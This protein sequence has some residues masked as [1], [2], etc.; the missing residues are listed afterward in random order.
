MAQITIAPG[1]CWQYSHYVGRQGGAGT[2]FGQPIGVAVGKGDVMYV[3]N[4][5]GKG[6]I[7][8]CTVGEEFIREFGRAEDNGE[9]KFEW[10]T[11]IAVD[12]DE[13]VYA[14]DEWLH[15]ITVFNTDGEVIS[16]WGEQGDGE[17]QLNGPSGLAVDADDNVWVVNSLNSRIQKFTKDGEFLGGFG[18]KGSGEGELEL[19]W[20]ITI[21]QGGDIY[22]ADWRNHR[23]QKFNANGDLL[24]TF[25][26]GKKTGV[27]PDGGTPYSHTFQSRTEVNPKDLN[28]PTGIAVDGDGDVYVVDWMNERVVIFDSVGEPVATLRGDASGLS[29][30]AQLSIN[31]NPDM[32]KARR[33]VKNPEIQNYFRMPVACAFDRENDRL[34]V[35][36]TLRSRVQ[37]Y[38][39][40]REYMDPQFNL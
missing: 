16:T 15:R 37:V 19:P 8:K 30:W 12:Q 20:G 28:H 26:S 24:M 5:G 27:S 22:I 32:E 33:R 35:A 11:A 9:D 6:R 10:L 21:D 3:A 4:R 14:S 39:K 7:S 23:V 1:R 36:D 29:K 31:A 18:T 25:G 34:L 40:D 13:N 2:G 17:G 38:Y